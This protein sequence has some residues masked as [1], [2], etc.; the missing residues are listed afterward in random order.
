MCPVCN[1]LA[2]VEERCPVCGGPMADGGAIENYLGPYSPYM[3]VDSLQ[4]FAP[5]RQC[6]H[7]LYCPR[8]HYDT[9]AAWELVMI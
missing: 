8:C 5:D 6:V 3:P 7:L 1:A 9:R 4:Q 2:S